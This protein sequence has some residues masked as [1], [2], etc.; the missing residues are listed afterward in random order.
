MSRSEHGPAY[1]IEH[2]RMVARCWSPSDAVKWRA[3]LDDSDL[4]LRPWIPWM[5]DEPKPLYETAGWLRKMRANFD[6]DESVVLGETGLYTRAG[7]GAREIGYL[8]V[9][10]QT[11]KGYAK[12][13]TTLMVKVA[14]EIDKIDR[15]EIHC[16]P[17]NAPSAAIPEKLGFKHEATLKRRMVAPDGEVHD[18][19]VWTLFAA[20]Y[21]GSPSSEVELQ[22]FD[23]L[24]ERL[25]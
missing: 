23:C 14:F 15:V 5:K 8:V 18:S 6:M 19:M 21:P 3:A 17:E 24:G 22:A 10:E 7:K 13:A 25:L 1:R 20:D 2:E 12:L 9:R 4:H 11:G 16:A